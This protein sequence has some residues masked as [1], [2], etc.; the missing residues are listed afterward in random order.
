MKSMA[1]PNLQQPQE[2]EMEES[3][4]DGQNMNDF[5]IVS[6][7]DQRFFQDLFQLKEVGGGVMA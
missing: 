7:M 6:D 1:R 2:E 3:S 4:E 5:T